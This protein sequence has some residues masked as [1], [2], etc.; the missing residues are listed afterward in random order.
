MGFCLANHRTVSRFFGGKSDP[1]NTHLQL[2]NEFAPVKTRFS[3]LQEG[4]H[5]GVEP[6]SGSYPPFKDKAVFWAERKNGRNLEA[7]F[8]FELGVSKK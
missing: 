4:H 6:G 1:E 7:E 3:H 2:G 5:V 8:F